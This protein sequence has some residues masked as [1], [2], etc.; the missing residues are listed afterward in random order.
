MRRA[1]MSVT[2]DRVLPKG[3]LQFGVRYLYSDMSG[4]GYGTDSLT[5]NQVLSLF[6]VSPSELASQG[7]AVDLVYGLA[8][9]VTLS[10]TG[11]FAQ[12]TMDHLSTLEGQ[13][14][15]YLFYQTQASG[16]QDVSGQC[17]L[18]GPANPGLPVPCHGRGI[19]ALGLHRGG[20]RHPLLRHLGHPASLFPATRLR[21]R[22]SFA[23]FTFNMQNKRASFG[24][25]GKARSESERMTGAGPWETSS[26]RTCGLG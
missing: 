16:I 24:L 10:A 18:R 23:G 26:G 11:T 2:E 14:N 22:G 21:D 4:Q 25:Q 17:P 19:G 1:P 9:R 6:D 8:D 20:R 15:A 5:V 12:K 13:P 7:F 3:G